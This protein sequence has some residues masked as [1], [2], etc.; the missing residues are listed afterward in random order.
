MNTLVLN[1]HSKVK[2]ESEGVASFI[3]TLCT[4]IDLLK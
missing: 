2:Q 1:V 4:R 3:L